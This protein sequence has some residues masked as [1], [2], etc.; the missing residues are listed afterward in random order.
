MTDRNLLFARPHVLGAARVMENWFSV[1]PT[2]VPIMRERDA[3]VKR[4]LFSVFFQPFQQPAEVPATALCL[5]SSGFVV[6]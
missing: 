4:Q 2:I 3:A 1:S 5:S 6:D